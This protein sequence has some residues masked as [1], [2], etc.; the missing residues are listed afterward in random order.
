MPGVGVA[1]AVGFNKGFAGGTPSDDTVTYHLNLP[2]NFPTE[3]NIGNSSTDESIVIV[4]SAT[5]GANRQYGEIVVL[6]PA[7]DEV[8]PPY[9]TWDFDDIG[10][11]CTTGLSGTDIILTL[12]VD[13]SS[14]DNVDFDYL[15]ERINRV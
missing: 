15:I 9:H 11:S 7:V 2:D 13:D 5:R 12:T 3:L 4:Y 14:L 10:L 1:V 6:C 8:R